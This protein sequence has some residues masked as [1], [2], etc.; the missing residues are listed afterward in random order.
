MLSS[1][2]PPVTSG[3]LLW[4]L[5]S[6]YHSLCWSKISYE[7]AC[8]KWSPWVNISI[9]TSFWPPVTYGDLLWLLRLKCHRQY[10]SGTYY[11]HNAKKWVPWCIFQFWPHFD[12]LWPPVTSN[13]FQSQNIISYI[14]WGYNK[15]MYTKILIPEG[16][17]KCCSN[18][19]YFDL[20]ASNDLYVSLRSKNYSL[21]R[22]L[23]SYEDACKKLRWS[24][25]RLRFDRLTR[26]QTHTQTDTHTHS[27]LFIIDMALAA[28]NEKTYRHHILLE[29]RLI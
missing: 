12:L 26:R 8:Q 19:P 10:R 9:L 15:S 28:F 4:L 6:K 1:F 5:R 17:L 2:W 29:V 14:G 25:L 21:W 13:G 20:F 16:I 7:N 23:V 27:A 18:W 3:D 24:V 11:E 22:I